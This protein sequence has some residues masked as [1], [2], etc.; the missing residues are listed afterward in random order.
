[1][2]RILLFVV[3]LV[4]VALVIGGCA[5]SARIDV[6]PSP[7]SPVLPDANDVTPIL[8]Q[9]LRARGYGLESE[10]SIRSIREH[11][12][13]WKKLPATQGISIVEIWDRFT[14]SKLIGVRIEVQ[15]QSVPPGGFALTVFSGDPNGAKDV[16]NEARAFRDFVDAT[17]PGQTIKVQAWRSSPT[18]WP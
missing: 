11:A 7:G 1:V 9:F 16:R 2:R 14:G 18:G 4:G 3:A 5:T 13:Y 8:D 15:L 10:S 12:N 17:F 6:R